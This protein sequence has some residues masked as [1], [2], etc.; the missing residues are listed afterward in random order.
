LQ[1]TSFFSNVFLVRT[2]PQCGG[3]VWIRE[4]T[5][6]PLPPHRSHE[7]AQSPQDPHPH[8][9]PPHILGT[10]AQ[11]SSHFTPHT[12]FLISFSLGTILQYFSQFAWQPQRPQH[13]AEPQHSSP[14]LAVWART[15]PSNMNNVVPNTRMRDSSVKSATRSVALSCF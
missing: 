10:G 4:H 9:C 8:P 3:L 6:Q 12:V 5:S 1:V 11:K 14:A 13:S 15:R 2:Q 7:S